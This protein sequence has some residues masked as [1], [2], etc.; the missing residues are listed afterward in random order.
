[1]NDTEIVKHY[2]AQFL[3]SLPP[4]AERPVE[5][6]EAFSFGS[7]KEST[8]S[9]TPLVLEGIKTATGSLLWS[10]EAE[11]RRPPMVGDYSIVTGGE[12]PV[13][14]LLDTEVR[15]LPY[16]QVDAAFAWDGGEE[17]RTLDSWRQM[18]WDYI[19]QECAR[20]GREPTLQVPLVCERF[21]LVYKEALKAEE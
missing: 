10:Y 8:R 4:G 18:Y 21:H 5:Y 14:V 15:I 11:G 6:Y 13:G 3:A 16:D 9:I 1:M 7:S 17:D 12:E 19:V 2:W 20:L